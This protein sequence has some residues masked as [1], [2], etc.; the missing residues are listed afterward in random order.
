VKELAVSAQNLAWHVNDSI[1]HHNF[2]SALEKRGLVQW[3]LE[4]AWGAGVRAGDAPE[5]CDGLVDSGQMRDGDR[6][7]QREERAIS[8]VWL[9]I[10]G[11]EDF[12]TVEL[13]F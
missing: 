4:P 13:Q 10:D 11:T 6:E 3:R 5:R 1:A 9:W 7:R 2:I 8:R 12:L